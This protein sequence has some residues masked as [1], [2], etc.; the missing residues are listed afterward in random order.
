[1]VAHA[2]RYFKIQKVS[3]SPLGRGVEKSNL[4]DVQIPYNSNIFVKSF[5]F[6]RWWNPDLDALLNFFLTNSFFEYV[7]P[8]PTQSIEF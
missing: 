8:L 4:M 1:M 7:H 2:L 3:M 5:K 6:F